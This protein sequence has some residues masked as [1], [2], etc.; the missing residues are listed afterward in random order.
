MGCA[1]RRARPADAGSA[2][3]GIRL[4]PAGSRAPTHGT[5]PSVPGL[6]VG[7]GEKKHSRPVD[8][9]DRPLDGHVSKAGPSGRRTCSHVS[10]VRRTRTRPPSEP[11]LPVAVPAAR[12]RLPPVRRP[13]TV[14]APSERRRRPP[15]RHGTAT[16]R[17]RATAP[18]LVM[19]REPRDT[20]PYRPEAGPTRAVPPVR[21]LATVDPGSS[22]SR[23]LTVPD[24]SPV[25]DPGRF[26]P[27]LGPGRR[28]RIPHRGGE[29]ARCP[30][31]RGSPAAGSRGPRPSADSAR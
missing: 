20:S 16:L 28:E 4:R 26:P 13:S 11:H 2:G 7:P 23:A 5:A 30:L 25:R 24:P 15:G 22:P 14:R 21:R 1:A 17:R 29:P 8:Y 31:I 10:S 18:A 27:A 19:R 12:S 6:G 9:H 3:R